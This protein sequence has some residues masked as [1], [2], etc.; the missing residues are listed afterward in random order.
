MK[1]PCWIWSCLYV[2]LFYA[3]L[4]PTYSFIHSPTTHFCF[5]FYEIT[6]PFLPGAVKTCLSLHLRWFSLHFSPNS[7]SF[8]RPPSSVLSL[9]LPIMLGPSHLIFP[10]PIVLPLNTLSFLHSPLLKFYF[11][12]QFPG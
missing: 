10:S 2:L 5:Q 7:Y 9:R 1:E 6:I 4:L 12:Q 8:L 3:T 11:L